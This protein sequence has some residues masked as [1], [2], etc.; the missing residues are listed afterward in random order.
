MT[1]ARSRTAPTI[2]L[3]GGIGSGKSA[4]ASLWRESGCCV[5]ES[6][7]LAREALGDATIRAALVERWGPS[8]VGVDGALDR[9]AI[10]RIVFADPAERRAL[11]ALTH[12]WIERTRR[13]MFAAAPESTPAFVIDAPLLLEVGLDRECDAVVFVDAPRRDRLERVRVNRSWTEQELDRRENAQWPLDRKRA[14]ATHIIANDADLATLR[15]RAAETLR[16]I[17]LGVRGPL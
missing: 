11:E 5:C 6:D 8:V 17:L 9:A 7:R 4:V 3:V 2:G 10:A 13:A 16:A 12:P 1:P 15:E 14:K